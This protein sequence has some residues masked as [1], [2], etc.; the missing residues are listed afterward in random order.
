MTTR[1]FCTS[2][3]YELAKCAVHSAMLIGAVCCAAYN[4]GAFWYRREPHNAVNACVYGALAIIEVVH[5]RH[6]LA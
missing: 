1:E 3:D 6:H 2:R 4:A 5:V